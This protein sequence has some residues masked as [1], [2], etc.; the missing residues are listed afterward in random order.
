MPMMMYPAGQSLLQIQVRIGKLFSLFS[1]K[2][3]IVGTQKNGLNKTVLL[4]TQTNV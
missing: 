2:T 4:S 3:Y 1:S